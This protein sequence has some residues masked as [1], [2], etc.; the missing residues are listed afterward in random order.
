MVSPFAITALSEVLRHELKPYKI[1]VSALFPPDTETPGLQEEL[2]TRPQELNIISESWG[3]LAT[4]EEVAEKYIKG[5]LKKKFN[6]NVCNS[7]P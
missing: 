7:L 1:G 6:I 5:V 4:A 3:G 2:E